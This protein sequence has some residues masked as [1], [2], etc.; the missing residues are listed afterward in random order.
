MQRLRVRCWRQRYGPGVVGAID[1]S[2]ARPRRVDRQWTWRSQGR[3]PTPSNTMIVTTVDV[4]DLCR[5]PI[6]RVDTGVERLLDRPCEF[7]RP[8]RRGRGESK[9]LVLPASRL[10]C[11]VAISGVEPDLEALGHPHP[12]GRR[13]WGPP[14]RKHDRGPSRGTRHRD[15]PSR[16]RPSQRVPRVRRHRPRPPRRH[17]RHPASGPAGCERE[18]PALGSSAGDTATSG[19]V[20]RAPARPAK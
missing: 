15:P 7:R 18:G 4:A 12:S 14:R 8:G 16:L 11:G 9:L 2:G 19:P 5:I 6:G 1:R 17:D 10:R 13:R 3:S 20:R